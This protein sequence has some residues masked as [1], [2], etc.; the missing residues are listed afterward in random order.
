MTGADCS[1]DHTP[2]CEQIKIRLTLTE[3]LYDIL[4]H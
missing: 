1:C 3:P 4:D 2:L